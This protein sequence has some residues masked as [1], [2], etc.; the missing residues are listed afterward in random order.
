VAKA[1]GL[2][3]STMSR[4]GDGSRGRGRPRW[5]DEILAMTK[6]PLA[7]VMYATQ[8]TDGAR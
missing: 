1:N 5:M 3:K 6:L 7:E 8:G 4:I 2:D